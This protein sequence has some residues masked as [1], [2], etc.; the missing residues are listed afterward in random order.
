M[1]PFIP[2]LAAAGSGSAVAGAVTLGTAALG[3]YSA[4]EQ[5]KAGQETAREMK[6]AAVREADAARGEEI[7]RRR[8]FMRVLSARA[9]EAGAKGVGTDGSI[10]AL[11]RTD[12]RDNRNDL[13]TSSANSAARQR[14]LRSQ[15]ASAVKQGNLAAGRSLLDTGTGLYNAVGGR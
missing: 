3:V 9:A 10:G 14:A 5:R 12:I 8:G 2:V 6:R 1:G 7:E 11:T 4:L 13:L 15:G